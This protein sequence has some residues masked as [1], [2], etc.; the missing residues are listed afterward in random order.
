MKITTY[1]LL[2]FVLVLT[3]TSCKKGCTDPYATNY[4]S[5]KTIDKGNCNVHNKVTLNS[6]YIKKIDQYNSAGVLW[7]NGGDNDL[8]QDNSHP[9]LSVTFR[10][11]SGYSYDPGIYYPTVNPNDVDW[12]LNLDVPISIEN[13]KNDNGFYVYFKEIDLDGLSSILMDS[14]FVDPFDFEASSNRFKDTLDITSGNYEFT[15]HMKWD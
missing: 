5:K 15:A 2:T 3:A 4:N 12:Q 10:A 8:D 6:I 1:L 14:I 13:W 7:D 11:E 9:D